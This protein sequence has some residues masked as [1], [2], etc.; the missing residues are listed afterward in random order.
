MTIEAEAPTPG[1]G[2]DE[3]RSA[4]AGPRPH[5]Q[6]V[7]TYYEETWFDYRCFW[8][9]DKNRALHFG[10]WDSGVRSHGQS[11]LRM[12]EVLAER[13]GITAGDRV[14]DAGCGVGG[15]SLWLAERIGARVHG[16]NLV[17]EQVL[18]ANR[19]ARERGLSDRVRF[20]VQDYAATTFPDGSF[21]VIWVQ[22]SFCHAPDKAAFWREAARLLA[23]G[24]RLVMHDYLRVGGPPP[25]GRGRELL[26]RWQDGWVM[27]SLATAEELR[28]WSADAGFTS[29]EVE[30]VSEWVAPSLRRL[31]RITLPFAPFLSLFHRRGWRSDAQHGNTVASLAQWRAFRRRLWYPGLV[32]ARR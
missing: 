24:G 8:M 9:D 10:W 16:I 20:E 4:G 12:N 7:E 5:A 6:A 11:L 31:Y 26:R 19:Y 1:P 28:Q 2:R 29:L 27:P 25:S 3:S 21:S 30:D 18:R 32:V 14:L 13:A 17:T 22:E 23:P 15:S